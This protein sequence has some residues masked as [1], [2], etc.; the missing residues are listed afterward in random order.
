MTDDLVE[1]TATLRELADELDEQGADPGRKFD[2]YEWAEDCRRIA[3]VLDKLTR[4]EPLEGPS[5]PPIRHGT[6]Q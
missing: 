2:F 3:A 4:K 5:P 1:M 6:C